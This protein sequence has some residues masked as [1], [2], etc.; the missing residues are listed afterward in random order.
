MTTEKNLKSGEVAQ[1]TSQIKAGFEITQRDEKRMLLVRKDRVVVGSVE[2]ADLKLTGASIAPIHAVIELKFAPTEGH[3]EGRILDLASPSGVLVNGVKVVNHI[4][5]SGDVITIGDATIAFGFR[6]PEFH[7]SLP[8]QA[9]LLVEENEIKPIFDYRPPVKE[10]LEVVYSWSQSILNVGHFVDYDKKKDDVLLGGEV[11][12]DFVVPAIFS[13]AGS[14]TLAS[15][16]GNRW[17]LFI[18]P[19]MK[20]VLYIDGELHSVE[21]YRRNKLGADARGSVT[22]G[23]NDFAKIEA[24]GV[25]FYLS[26]TLAP[27][28]LRSSSTVVAD[29]FL[30]KTLIISL[31]LSAIT[32]FSIS[33]MEIPQS[34]VVQVPETIA[35]ILYHP[36]KYQ[37]KRPVAR[38]TKKQEPVAEEKPKKTEVDFTKPK[39][40]EGKV[41]QTKSSQPGKKQS[42]QNMAKGGEGARAKGT[43]GKRGAHVK[44]NGTPQNAANRPSPEAGKERGGTVSQVADNGNVQMLKGA[45]NKILDLLGGSGEKIGKSGSKLSGFGGFTTQGDG[46]LA[47]SGSGKGGGGTADTLLGGTGDKGRGGGK[48]GTGLGAEGTGA[49]IVGGKTR[50]ELNVGGGDETVVVGAI[51]R[52][53]IDA[54][55]KAHRDEFRYC[56]SKELNA[57]QPNLGGKVVAA[58]VIGGSG[59]A[60]QLAVASSS[61][62]SPNVE[63]CVLSVVSRIQFPLPAGGVPVTI[64][65]PFGFSSPK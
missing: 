54:A 40:K 17:V 28:I 23:E 25:T 34:E 43:E 30:T 4:L 61:I 44:Q 48:V 51:D 1:A 59:R 33:R 37:T 26:R 56:Y 62:G 2:S 58:F 64:K 29:P 6:K 41:A 10:A 14:Y 47:L 9:L 52:D 5:K 36:E 38:E 22:L 11:G 13:T 45:T 55:I 18:D 19:K 39:E 49:G 27:P 46:G 32:I 42:G 53:A 8:D 63:R 31:L 15:K 60:S 16:A 21:D 57:G 12:D 24:G 35:T 20:G 65:Y 50:V 7:K 3:S